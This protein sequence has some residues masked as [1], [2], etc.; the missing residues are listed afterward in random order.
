LQFEGW[1]IIQFSGWPSI[2]VGTFGG[3]I[4]SVDSSISENGKF[5]VIVK[6]DKDEKWPDERFLRHGAKAQGWILLNNVSL[7][8][9]FWRQLNS[10]PPSFDSELK[11]A[12]TKDESKK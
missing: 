7:G 9:E 10:F 3:I 12:Q 1:P 2:A 6:K 11:A 5:R 4:S 8:Y